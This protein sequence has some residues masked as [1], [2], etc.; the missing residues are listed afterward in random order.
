MNGFDALAALFEKGFTVLTNS[1]AAGIY[2][3]I[4][5]VVFC[6]SGIS[7]LLNP[8]R[9]AWAMVDF[10]VVS[11]PKKEFGLGLGVFELLVALG[12][13]AEAGL[14]F[15][16]TL[17][18]GSLAT[19]SVLIARAILRGK[20]FECACFGGSHP[21]DWGALLRTGL[22]TILAIFTLFTSLNSSRPPLSLATDV[23][24]LELITALAL[25]GIS[26]LLPQIRNLLKWNQLQL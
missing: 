4:L 6:W 2:A 12:L 3:A 7:K 21:L 22:L 24:Q 9:A 10:E 19:F 20:Q 25:C 17:A 26:A 23:G 1:S 18:A 5:A 13:A 16:L 15:F 11:R 8:D 14:P